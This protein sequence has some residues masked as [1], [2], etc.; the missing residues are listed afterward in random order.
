[1]LVK[2][3]DDLLRGSARRQTLVPEQD[4]TGFHL[5]TVLLC[6]NKKNAGLVHRGS[7]NLGVLQDTFPLGGWVGLN[8]A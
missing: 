4:F 1:M 8:S 5:S 2:P 6:K 7:H 3:P